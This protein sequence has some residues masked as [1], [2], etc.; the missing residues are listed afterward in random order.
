MFE[1]KCKLSKSNAYLYREVHHG[2]SNMK[3]TKFTIVIVSKIFLLK[4]SSSL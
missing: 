4:S 3:C 2:P 1:F